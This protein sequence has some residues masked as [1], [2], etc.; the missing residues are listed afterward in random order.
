MS[1]TYVPAAERDA[2]RAAHAVRALDV[3]DLLLPVT[4]LFAV[5]A[6]ALAYGAQTLPAQS[7]ALGVVARSA[8]AAALVIVNINEA[9]AAIE[10]EPRLATAF[11][12]PG[13]RRFAARELAQHL[14]RERDAGRPLPNVGAIASITVP[15]ATVERQAGLDV[16]AKRLQAAR[17]DAERAGLVS[18][19]A[20]RL[21][22]AGELAAIKP[23]LAVR[24]PETFRRRVVIYGAGYM[25]AFY[26]VAAVWRFRG[27]EGDRLLLVAA[28]LLTAV[29]FAVLITRTDPLRDTLLF[30]RYTEGVVLGAAIMAAASLIDFRKAA[31]LELSFL[32]LVGALLLSVVLVL[33]GDGPGSSSAKVNL[34]PFQPI[35]LIRLLLAL[36]LAGYFARRWELLRQDRRAAAVHLRWLPL[37]PV[38]YA[39]PVV[40]GV[41]AALVF[42]FLQKDLGP[43]LFLSCV[44][45]AM[46]AV[47]R[48]RVVMAVVGLAMLAGGFYIGYRL[49]ISDTLLA[50]VTMW[51]SPWDNAVLGGDQIAQSL[52]ALATGGIFGT[53]L[54]FGDAHYLPAGHTDLVF[55]TIGEELGMAGLLAVAAVY[56]L[57][58]WRGF[59]IAIAA[60]SDYGFF[61]AT[62]VTLFLVVPVLVMGAGALGVTPLTG[63]VTP[64]LSYGGSAMAANFAALGILSAIRAGRKRGAVVEEQLR[65]PIRYL[66]RTLA[67]IAAVLF[68]ALIDVQVVRADAYVVKPHLGVQADGV[69]RYQYNRRVLDVA[70]LIPRGN[71]YDR[72]RRLLASSDP[73]AAA[74]ARETYKKLG[75]ALNSTCQEPVERCYPL[76]GVGFHL[77]GDLPTRINWSAG[78]TSYVER[79]AESRLRGFDDRSRIIQTRDRAGNLSSTIRRE[80]DELVPLLRHRHDLNDPDVKPILER[81][82]NLTLTVDAALQTRMAKTLAAHAKKSATGRAAA[83]VLDPAT[84]DVLALVSYPWPADRPADRTALLGAEG[85]TDALLDRARY[86]LY[87]P[88]ST[89]KLVT[90]TAALRRRLDLSGTTFGCIRLPDGRVGASIPGWNRPIRDDVQDAHPHGTINMRDGLVRSCN[91]YFAQLALR[92]GPDAILE[93]ALRLGISVAPSE[94][95]DRLRATLPQVGYGQGDVVASPLRMAR[96]AAAVASGGV[97]RDARVETSPQPARTDLLLPPEAAARLASY[98]RD[99]VLHGTGRTLR[100]H[101][102]RIAGKTGTAQVNGA[103]SHSWFVGF[104]PYG[105]AARR[106]AF[107]VIIE[108][109]GYGGDAAAPVAGE[110]VTAAMATGLIK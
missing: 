32:P 42:F 76:G 16:Y 66:G 109:A 13:D 45:L 48:G 89:F 60:S 86:G 9:P 55:S 57:I 1:V 14:V 3:R 35:E 12:I 46:Y 21:F 103:A 81:T 7:A 97:L 52:W 90:A 101:P 15:S 74:E 39:L 2:R 79:D 36:F 92:V 27:V 37:P 18:P 102:G 84:G 61:L 64:F 63:V 28:H 47:A 77:L 8:K 56:A 20:I 87:P 54:G 80:Y 75:M 34:G 17:L 98:M 108:N 78:N 65:R 11:A 110:I 91:A 29:G 31:F 44:F 10:L 26:L 24:A 50:R 51:R 99:T 23:G 85:G 95:P 19:D 62:A 107:A 69:R 30:V 96:V 49:N 72:R 53:G 41:G 93:T 22:T 68:A 25:L 104:A 58:V 71:V 73:A 83:V 67:A 88:G 43:A 94:S 105:P 70:A 82:R 106:I 59:R 4:S 6:I 40:V 38:D 33:F 100:N 5:L